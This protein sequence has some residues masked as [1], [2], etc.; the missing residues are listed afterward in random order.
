MQK[1]KIEPAGHRKR[2]AGAAAALLLAGGAA[3]AWLYGGKPASEAPVAAPAA[4]PGLPAARAEPASTAVAGLPAPASSAQPAASGVAAP[5]LP[6]VAAPASRESPAE[7]LRKVQLALHGGSPEDALN[8]ARTL[9]HC[10]AMSKV[11]EALF[12]VRDQ[13]DLLPPP[14]KKMLKDMGGGD[15]TSEQIA[16]AQDEQ[17]R[18][19]VFDAATLARSDELLHKAYEGQAPGSAMAYLQSL[20]RPD[21]TA[22]AD[23]A[24][25][26]RLQADVRKAAQAGD[27]DTV[28]ALAMGSTGGATDLGITPAQRLGYKHAALQIQEERFPGSG[29]AMQKVIDAISQ[30]TPSAPLTA[31]QQREADALAQQVVDAW[32]RGRKS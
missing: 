23:P 10:S 7:T 32:R 1:T 21:A 5:G 22:K 27:P 30:M 12:A 11:P 19:Q 13:P 14:V 25:V 9:Q 6:A 20:Q 15:V 28:M 29:K 2:H 18:C 26:A 8:A 4:A 24:L 17:R 16:H 3:V 31:A